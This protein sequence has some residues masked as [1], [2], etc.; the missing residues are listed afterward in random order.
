MTRKRYVM[1][2]TSYVTRGPWYV[3]RIPVVTQ[4][5]LHLQVVSQQAFEPTDARGTCVASC[6]QPAGVL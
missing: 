4:P 3:I 5:C 2:D 1:Y 6:L